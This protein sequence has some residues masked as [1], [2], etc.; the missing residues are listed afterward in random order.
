MSWR[1]GVTSPNDLAKVI[2]HMRDIGR[3]IQADGG[4][5]A[6][7]AA[8]LLAC[9][10]DDPGDGRTDDQ[11]MSDLVH[12][13]NPDGTSHIADVFSG[14]SHEALELI[15]G[16]QRAAIFRKVWDNCTLY[17]Y[18]KGW[19]AKPFRCTKSSMVHL[20]NNVSLLETMV[21]ADALGGLDVEAELMAGKELGHYSRL[22]AALLAAEIDSGNHSMLDIARSIIYGDNEVG[23]VSRS[24]IIGLLMSRN[25]AA[26]KM[27]GDL[28]L[29]ARLQEGLRQAVVESADEGSKEGFMYILKLIL[30]NDLARFSSVAR[31]V[32]VWTGLAIPPDRPAA[33]NRCLSLAL[34][35]LTDP[36]AREVHLQSQDVLEIYM[37]L[38]AIAFDEV[39]DVSN[40]I[41]ALLTSTQKYKRLA[42][43]YFLGIAQFTQYRNA[44]AIMLLGDDDVETV[45]WCLWNLFSDCTIG[46]YSTKEPQAWT[47]PPG[48]PEKVSPEAIYRALRNVLAKVP[49]GGLEFKESLFPWCSVS[50]TQ[51]QVIE[52]MLLCLTLMPDDHL[53][54]EMLPL[55]DSMGAD[56]R[57]GFVRR[58]LQKPSTDGLKTALVEA[59]GDKASNVRDWAQRTVDSMQLSEADFVFIEDLLRHKAGDMRRSCVRLL[60]RQDAPAL[61]GSID[62][63]ASSGV[64][65][66]RLG[67]IELVAAIK[68]D[69]RFAGV[70]LQAKQRIAALENKSQAEQ[71]M[72]A[73][74]TDTDLPA[75][76]LKNGFGLYN[77][78]AAHSPKLPPPPASGDV[79][80][81]F[82]PPVERVKAIW[83]RLSE[84]FHEH[85]EYEYDAKH[86]DD[87]RNTVVLGS[88]F[89]CVF[90]A[91]GSRWDATIDDYPLSEVW[92]GFER[93]AG[94]SAADLLSMTY[95]HGCIH[96][97]W[98]DAQGF[99]RDAAGI[100][101][102]AD[103][104]A[105]L[106][107][108]FESLPYMRH[109]ATL[110][111][112]LAHRLPANERFEAGY[113]AALHL[114]HAIPLHMHAAPVAVRKAPN[115]TVQH[116]LHFCESPQLQFWMNAMWPSAGDDDYYTR[117]FEL[118]YSLYGAANALGRMST[119][120]FIR[121][122]RAGLVDENEMLLELMGRGHSRERI[123]DVTSGNLR[124]REAIDSF[125]YM[126]GVI[127]KA[128][129][130]I[131]EIEVGRGEMS[132]PV[133]HLADEV[134]RCYGVNT[135]AAILLKMEK[136]CYIRGYYHNWGNRESTRKEMLSHLLGCCHPDPG[137]DAAKLKAALAGKKVTDSML[138]DAAM[139][140][141]Q[142]LAI[143]ED[144]LE[145]PGLASACWFFRAH[146]NTSFLDDK[147]NTVARYSS[148]SPEDFKDGALDIAWFR[149]AHRTLGEDRFRVAYQAAKYVAAAAQHRR[150]QLYSDAVTGRLDLAATERVVT[151]KRSRDHLLA[152][153]VIPITG[154]ADTRH[155]YELIQAFLKEAKGFGALR[156]ASETTA[157][158]IA[159]EN[160]ARNAGF[161]DA[162]RLVWQ[163]ESASFHDAAALFSQQ[164]IDGIGARLA[165]NEAGVV[166]LEVT[167][168]GKPLKDVPSALKKHPAVVQMKAVQKDLRAQH[169]RARA[170]LEAAMVNADLFTVEELTKLET[171]PVIAPLLRN[172]VFR[173]A[174][175]LGYFKGGC[176]VAPDGFTHPLGAAAEVR[177]AHPVD[178]HE[179]GVWPL[180]QRD[181][182]GRRIVQPFKQVFRELYMPN[183]DELNEPT[184]SQRYAG[185][186][187]QPAKTL[188]L[189]RT[190][191]WVASHEEGL[192]KVHHK[193][194]IVV[195]LWTEADWFSPA[196]I[197]PPTLE[198]VRFH[199][200]QTYE[201]APIHKIPPI[202]F[203]EAMRDVDLAVSVAHAGGVDPE[204]SA[205]TVE[206]RRTL[207]AEMLKLM[208]IDNV[209]IRKSHAFIKGKL[210]EYTVHLGSATVQK[211]ATGSIF[212]VPVHSQQRGRL[213]LPFMDDDP[214]TAEVV[215]KI[216]L[217]AEDNK[218]RDP[219]ILAQIRR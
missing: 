197:E 188:A 61:L 186:Q 18:N 165:V 219:A 110:L 190:R 109:C 215:S 104:Y 63:L 64:E 108:F 164:H 3:R 168:D 45:A 59:L 209:E 116:E 218:L 28:L 181:L 206:M 151:E 167:S 39:G 132:T 92:L 173:S 52:K 49:K 143:V 23:A 91:A 120:S 203:S 82:E 56:L 35:C 66:K 182:F 156:Q 141:P 184:A 122:F 152:Y 68:G 157:G 7:L 126:A 192:Q 210:G 216:V 84:L 76:T 138:V 62:R 171:H 98:L 20:S 74:V 180:Y 125:P 9:M 11:R 187:V 214:K 124:V 30:N 44:A 208:R 174:D 111:N 123:R 166:E 36:G 8:A 118:A 147:R 95:V 130:R 117:Y 69:S 38:W 153:S 19:M 1:W 189:L 72:A 37:S 60:L 29:A 47:L 148:I 87:S 213:F 159:L 97:P 170:S 112:L 185:H 5:G 217:L 194:N 160:L 134:A 199:H 31:A 71:L 55:R 169:S 183:E 99:M 21:C 2:A 176:L 137:D 93:D 33:L 103:D 155:R 177:I 207:V 43:L 67:A 179:L 13:V 89:T 83:S 140:A 107:R 81:L 200:R 195:T 106:R 139:Y 96:S 24:L 6:E 75:H 27:A 211:M 136:D 129:R 57:G 133:S 127:Q 73:K 17:S 121:A 212:I 149:D 135:F 175:G 102:C 77:P 14:P 101:L 191:G 145:W 113:S 114:F 25:P 26:H 46:T 85:R 162:N 86:W 48:A 58:F 94:L 198:M 115:G 193:E 163:M 154:E 88:E 42:A 119:E 34:E 204:A 41:H 158:R 51:S 196:D 78:S 12:L 150:A 202:L 53:V 54:D 205:S 10:S 105:S 40:P 50:I 79:K 4:P 80:A 172:L 144:Y 70:Y 161:R 142:W 128:V 22:A 146:T 90:G 100:G 201:P 32:G 178:M 131:T 16:R 15:L 65:N